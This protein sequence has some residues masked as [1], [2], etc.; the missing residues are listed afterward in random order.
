MPRTQPSLLPS[1]SDGVDAVAQNVAAA[2]TTAAQATDMDT[3]EMDRIRDFPEDMMF[4]A[5]MVLGEARGE[6]VIP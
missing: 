5:F 6:A 3:E 1:L 2:S 4:L